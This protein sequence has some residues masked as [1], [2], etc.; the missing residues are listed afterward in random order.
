MTI[1]YHIENG[2]HLK[3]IAAKLYSIILIYYWI[4]PGTE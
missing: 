4:A 1:L 2:G 3:I